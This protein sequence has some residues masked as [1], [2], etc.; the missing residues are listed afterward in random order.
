MIATKPK[1][2]PVMELLCSLRAEPHFAPL[3]ALKFDMG[4]KSQGQLRPLFARLN[5]RGIETVVK[6][7]PS[8][9]WGAAVARH[10]WKCA[11]TEAEV[12]WQK[13]YGTPSTEI[14]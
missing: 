2:D 9:G 1:T 14:A 11:E 4:Y 10:C 13:T 5:Q 8:G 12:Y 3:S 6:Q 7:M